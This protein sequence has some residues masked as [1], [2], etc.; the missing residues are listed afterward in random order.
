M[1]DNDIVQKALALLFEAIPPGSRVI[2]F[3]SRGRN[4]AT[5]R[6]DYDFLVVEPEIKDRFAEMVRLSS[7]LGS[8]LIPADV[9]VLNRATFERRCEDP[10]SLAARAVKEGQ[11][12][13]S[14]A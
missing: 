3:G 8:S 11:V 14:A 9:V 7:I 1:Q 12:Y 6:S 10:N 2:L 13:D 5:P 4:A